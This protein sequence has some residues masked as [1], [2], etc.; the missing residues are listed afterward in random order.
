MKKLFAFFKKQPVAS[1]TGASEEDAMEG[2]PAGQTDASLVDVVRVEPTL[3]VPGDMVAHSRVDAQGGAAVAE[4]VEPAKATNSRKKSRKKSAE[5]VPDGDPIFLYVGSLSGCSQKDVQVFARSLAEQYVQAPE[6]ASINI[7]RDK[8]NNRYIYEI[9][10]G[11]PRRSVIKPLL[12][13]LEENHHAH[14]QL[15]NGN[16]ATIQ[17]E[18]DSLFTL[19]YQRDENGAIETFGKDEGNSAPLPIQ[20]FVSDIALPE[21]FPL[22]NHLSNYATWMLKTFGFFFL[23]CGT[24]WAV[25]ASGMGNADIL[26]TQ[27]RAGLTPDVA[28]NPIWHLQEAKEAAAQEKRGLLY[29]Q[30]DAKGWDY[31]LK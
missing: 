4:P 1:A 30:K 19:V 22:Q 7:V 28:D 5:P 9:H 10:E 29:I 13:H 2:M 3:E 31:K 15:A 14:I 26:V 11:G 25:L 16:R 24:V 18:A 23:L 21:L 20:A 6:L 27:L 17:L 12:A 8:P